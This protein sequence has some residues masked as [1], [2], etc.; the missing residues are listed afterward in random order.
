MA[1]DGCC[2]TTL[3]AGENEECMYSGDATQEQSNCT[4]NGGNW[5]TTPQ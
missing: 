5:T 3:D 4:S 1:L 2:I